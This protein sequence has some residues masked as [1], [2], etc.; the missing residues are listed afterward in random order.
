MTLVVL[1]SLLAALCFG[2]GSA[3]Q[4]DG[5][6]QARRRSPLNPGLLADLAT[7]RVWL[8]GLCAQ[9]AG[10]ALHLLAVNLGPI[11]LVQPLLTVGLVIALWLQRR[12]GRPV[13]SRA[14]LAAALVV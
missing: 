7:R 6:L 8:L 4:H 9:G 11:S 1:V 14:L 10:V 3:L 13:S 12:A 2:A 5:A